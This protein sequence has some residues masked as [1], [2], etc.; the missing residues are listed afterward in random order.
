M[1]RAVPGAAA[2]ARIGTGF[3]ASGETREASMFTAAVINHPNQN[4]GETPIPSV[5]GPFRAL[6]VSGIN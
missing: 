4:N 6:S 5:L 2:A 1:A 3:S